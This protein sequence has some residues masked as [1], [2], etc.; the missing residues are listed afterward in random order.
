[1]LISLSVIC[2]L[3]VS[4]E[5]INVQINAPPVE[6]SANTELVKYMASVCGVKAS[7]VSLERVNIYYFIT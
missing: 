6:G 3:D 5:A 4:D 7:H 1:M 2:I